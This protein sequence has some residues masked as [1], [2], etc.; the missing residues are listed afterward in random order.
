MGV[1]QHG[2]RSHD[3]IDGGR[4]ARRTLLYP[5]QSL[6]R[7]P[8]V[9][10][11]LSYF[12]RIINLLNFF[13]REKYCEGRKLNRKQHLVSVLYHRTVGQLS[14]LGDILAVWTLLVQQSLR[15]WREYQ[16]AGS[17]VTGHSGSERVTWKTVYDHRRH[18]I[19]SGEWIMAQA[20]PGVTG[21]VNLLESD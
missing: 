18:F 10:L 3:R 16:C 19:T 20:V 1:G 8:A 7:R 14:T 21:E 9:S 15:R 6:F 17:R 5:H 2:G 12:R 13:L 4:S 11:S